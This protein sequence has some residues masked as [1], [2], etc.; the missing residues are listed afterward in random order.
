MNLYIV[1]I[2]DMILCDTAVPIEEAAIIVKD[3][4]QEHPNSSFTIST[5]IRY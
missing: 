3:A 2:D 1:Y 4:E 5:A